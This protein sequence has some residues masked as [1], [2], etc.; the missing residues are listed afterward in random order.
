[1]SF[2]SQDISREKLQSSHGY[3][4]EDPSPDL[5]GILKHIQEAAWSGL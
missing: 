2:V 3:Y 5:K 4:R 1:M